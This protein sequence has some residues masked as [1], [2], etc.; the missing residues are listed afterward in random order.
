MDYAALKLPG[1]SRHPN[2]VTFQLRANR[3]FRSL[4]PREGRRGCN[5]SPGP[6]VVDEVVELGLSF[7]LVTSYP[8]HVPLV[9]GGKIGVDDHH[10]LTHSLSMSDVFAKDDRLAETI[11]ALN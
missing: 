11:S 9:R 5:P 6:G 4:S 8:H 2:Q 7:R 3:R 10:R 1:V